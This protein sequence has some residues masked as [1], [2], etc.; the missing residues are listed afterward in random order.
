MPSVVHSS[1]AQNH[2]RIPLDEYA[3]DKMVDPEG[4]VGDSTIGIT[5]A[6]KMVS[7]MSGSLLTSLLGKF[8]IATCRSQQDTYLC[9]F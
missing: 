8:H 1:G 9:S 7:A 4:D 2:D 6:Q 5:A 3:M